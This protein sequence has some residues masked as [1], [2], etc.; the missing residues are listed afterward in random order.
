MQNRRER[1]VHML[2]GTVGLYR[3]TKQLPYLDCTVRGISAC[4]VSRHWYEP[5]ATEVTVAAEELVV[6]DLRVTC[7]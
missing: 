6:G 1:A 5:Y 4:T 2:A 3:L 7:Q